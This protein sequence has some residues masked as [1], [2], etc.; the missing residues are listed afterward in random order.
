MFQCGFDTL[1]CNQVYA[2]A[3]TSLH[4]PPCFRSTL[5]STVATAR[6]NGRLVAF[7]RSGSIISDRIAGF[8]DNINRH[9]VLINFGGSYLLADT[10]PR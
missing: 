9:Q 6:F 2:V 7:H 3:P 10:V 8:Q 4:I 5:F 1:E